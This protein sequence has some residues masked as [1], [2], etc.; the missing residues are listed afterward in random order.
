MKAAPSFMLKN[1]AAA[2][3]MASMQAVT[4]HKI[5]QCARPEF[6]VHK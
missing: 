1:D 4:D 2:Q 3:K 5:G 6:H